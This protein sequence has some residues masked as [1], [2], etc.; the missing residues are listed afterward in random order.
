MPVLSFGVTEVLVAEDTARM[1]GHYAARNY[2]QTVHTPE[3]QDFVKKFHERFGYPRGAGQSGRSSPIINMR[4]WIEAAREAGSGNLGQ[5]AA[6]DPAPEP[7]RARGDRLARSDHTS[8]A[9]K[10]RASA[11]RGTMGSSISSGNRDARWSPRHFRLTARGKSGI[12]C[13]KSLS[14]TGEQKS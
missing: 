9:G 1:A 12:F 6:H 4:M 5:C 8:C 10:W 14:S 13:S 11:G 3:N 7:A 2:F